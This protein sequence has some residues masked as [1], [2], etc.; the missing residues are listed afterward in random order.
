MLLVVTIF[1]FCLSNLAS[2]DIAEISIRSSGGQVTPENLAQ[3][4]IDLGLDQ[5]LV[6]IGWE[7][8]SV[9]ISAIHLSVENRL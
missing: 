8:R 5:P 6:I 4:R 2:G 9:L 3:A 7:K 1:A